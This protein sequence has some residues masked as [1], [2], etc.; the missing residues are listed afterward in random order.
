MPDKVW[1]K[2]GAAAL[3]VGATPKE[4]RYWEKVIPDLKPRRS[5]G[6][7]RYYHKDELP[8]LQRIRRWLAEGFTVSDC[9]GLLQGSPEARSMNQARPGLT[10]SRL[11]GQPCLQ[12]V[13]D[14]LRSLHGR[15]GMPPGA[16]WADANRESPPPPVHRPKVRK[17]FIRKPRASGSPIA[18]GLLLEPEVPDTAVEAPAPSPKRARPPKPAGGVPD[19]M[20]SGG[21]LPLECEEE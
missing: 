20:W 3:Q 16:A 6:N 4:L 14:A 17:A 5:K 7:F 15:L 9:V 13:L 8:R 18:E 10:E 2:I 12:V 21:R 11:S 19:P 1:F